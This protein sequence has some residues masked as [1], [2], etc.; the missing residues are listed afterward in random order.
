[1]EP[2]AT[3]SVAPV[4]NGDNG[5][6]TGS[7]KNFIE[8]APPAIL[9]DGDTGPGT[10]ANTPRTFSSAL[11]IAGISDEAKEATTTEQ[12]MTI[13]QGLK[14]YKPGTFWS[15][16]LST[17]VIMEGFDLALIASF[18]AQSQFNK[19]YGE[20]GADGKFFLAAQWKAGLTVG[21]LVGE[22][23]GL[24][25]CGIVS[26]KYGY[27]K[28]MVGALALMIAGIFVPFFAPNVQTLLAGQILCGIPWGIFQTLPTAYASEVVPQ[29]LRPYLCTYINLCWIM[30]QMIAAG[31]VRGL[32]NRADEWAYRIPFALQWVWPL[33]LLV[34][35]LFMPESPWWLVRKGLIEEAR[36]S[37]LR[38]TTRAD[39]TFNVDAT[40]S[41]INDTNE[42][43]KTVSE[44]TSYADCF[45][46]IDLR[47]TEITCAVWLIQAMCGSVFMGYAT[48][49]YKEAGLA[50]DWAFNFTL[51]Q[52]ALG[53]LGTFVSWF[54]M[55]RCGRRTL[56]LYGSITLFF[57][58]LI[59]GLVALL[60]KYNNPA[61]WTVASILLLFTFIYGCTVGPVCF[62]LVAELSSTR[63]KAKSIVLAR[64]S[65]NIGSI[66]ANTITSYQLTERSSTSSGW[67]WGAK[68]ALF[69]AGACA[70][71]VIWIYFR[72]PEPKNRSYVQLDT[73]F[74]RGVSASKFA[75]TDV[76]MEVE[77]DAVS[78]KLVESGSDSA[79]E[80]NQGSVA[81]PAA[82]V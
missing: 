48:L 69:W 25:I 4:A 80:G 70:L 66:I 19:T 37:L 43:E 15:I 3:S 36:A 39:P 47:R 12:N 52:Y 41:L 21:A 29:V 65:Y 8:D 35:V 58:L 34:G 9:N 30:G 51:I 40:I 45:K 33:P 11:N 5:P 63:L 78:V 13:K 27:R 50:E 68:S 31:V 72:L 82:R 14:I 73:L 60:P 57:F 64:N 49:F 1:M 7:G 75:T 6:Q 20:L 67:G 54:L 77:L 23:G 62:A 16:L 61:Q 53:V 71:C 44:G 79:A 59:I 17:A 46:G 56:Y 81:P 42:H 32:L 26:E 76:A 2:K 28:T 55:S 18:Y 10:G 38:L 24:F 22:I 74:E